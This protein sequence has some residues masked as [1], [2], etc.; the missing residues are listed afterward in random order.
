M[1]NYINTL[2]KDKY[3]ISP[4]L[5]KA[6]KEEKLNTNK[7]T[8]NEGIY[9]VAV[10]LLNAKTGTVIYNYIYYPSL[11][12][13]TL[14][15]YI[16]IRNTLFNPQ[17]DIFFIVDN[18]LLKNTPASAKVSTDNEP[19]NRLIFSN[20]D[21]LDNY[22]RTNIHT[23]DAITLDLVNM[24]DNLIYITNS[25]NETMD[26]LNYS[27]QKD[28]KKYIGTILKPYVDNKLISLE[29]IDN[30]INVNLLNC[31]LFVLKDINYFKSKAKYNGYDINE[32]P[33]K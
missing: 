20:L 2:S 21:P 24:M 3:I 31:K 8:K 1:L 7:V 12:L 19:Y 18:S 5:F 6:L 30:N 17:G 14:L 22:T 9:L 16:T 13:E 25:M 15:T 26:I 23:S 27:I 29:N 10:R 11:F 32:G 28:Y 33:Q 4:E